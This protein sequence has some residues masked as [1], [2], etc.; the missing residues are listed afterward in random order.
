MRLIGVSFPRTG[1][2]GPVEHEEQADRME[3][4][5]AEMEEDSQKLGRQIDATKG[6]W[7]TKEQDGS[8]PGA[9]PDH[10]EEKPT[11]ETPGQESDQ[12][13]EE[14]PAGQVQDDDGGSGRDEAEQGGGGGHGEEDET[15]TGNPDAAGVEDPDSDDD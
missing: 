1:K 11:M 8:V 5:A 2:G 4:Q 12:L 6:D 3:R 7:E 13:P 10:G 15:G 9:Q 14:G